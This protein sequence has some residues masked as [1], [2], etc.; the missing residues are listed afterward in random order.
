MRELSLH[1]MDIIE[2]GISA[3]A[4]LI[5]LEVLEKK[6]ENLLI[7][8]ITD[9][10]RGIPQDALEKVMDPFYTT[11]KT[12]RVGLGLS[13]FREA[14]KRCDGEFRLSSKEGKG[15]E[16]YAS[17]RMNHIDMP[18]IGDMAGSFSCLIMGNSK[19]DF[20][21][22]HEVDNKSFDIDTRHI[23]QELEGVP[24]NS[25]EVLRHLTNTVRES[26]KELKS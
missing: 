8:K 1:I 9:N 10:G 22:M 17:F 23:R 13:L 25:P 24:I 2:N 4:D 20:V 15:T 16:V 5:T 18:P 21:Y 6:K 14:A 19:V 7:I 11:R 26:L 3:G 12:R